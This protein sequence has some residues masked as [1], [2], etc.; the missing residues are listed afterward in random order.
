MRFS[1]GC[2][3]GKGCAAE[4][5]GPDSGTAANL[6]ADWTERVAGFERTS[7]AGWSTTNG[8]VATYDTA[9]TGDYTVRVGG[10]YMGTSYDVL[11]IG[12]S[13]SVLLDWTD[14]NNYAFVRVENKF[15]DATW[16]AAGSFFMEVGHVVAGV[17]TIIKTLPHFPLIYVN[18]NVIVSNDG[19]V[20]VGTMNLPFAEP[21]NVQGWIRIDGVTLGGSGIVGLKSDSITTKLNFADFDLYDCKP[22]ASYNHTGACGWCG[23]DEAEILQRYDVVLDLGAGGWTASSPSECSGG[24][25]N[26]CGD[27]QGEFT[28]SYPGYPWGAS[29]SAS[30]HK[31]CRWTYDEEW[32]DTPT[33]AGWYNTLHCEFY[34]Y[35]VA[36]GIEVTARVD[37]WWGGHLRWALYK[38]E[39]DTADI[40]DD[41]CTQVLTLPKDTEGHSGSH[42]ACDGGT[43]PDTVTITP[44]AD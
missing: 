42:A 28:L 21:P 1:P 5:E 36:G 2:N 13:F 39:Y 20:H 16:G 34:I 30:T 12:D 33:L 40:P 31:I 38:L 17:E 26:T 44:Q 4:Y 32:C 14:S 25:G 11:D 19:I 8:A 27:I 9:M 35:A 7:G 3:C 24:A 29:P 37:L 41:L 10:A 23:A 18:L 22:C 43:M 15:S 6:G